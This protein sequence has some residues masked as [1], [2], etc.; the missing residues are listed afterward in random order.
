MQ[1]KS[2]N[3]FVDHFIYALNR[4][5]PLQSFFAYHV[6]FSTTT[7]HLNAYYAKNIP[8]HSIHHYVDYMCQYDPINALQQPQKSVMTQLKHQHIP[9]P[10]SDF[11]KD[12]QV[13]DNIELIFQA[14]HENC[15][16]ISLIRSENEQVFSPQEIEM[17]QSCYDLAQYNGTKHLGSQIANTAC[18]EMIKLLTRSER[19]V[20]TLILTGKKN[21]EIADALFVSLATVKTHIYHIFQKTMVKSK[22]ELILKALAAS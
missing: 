15:L 22:R 1:T 8:Q 3:Q 13:L 6:K 12:N 2:W 14:D 5:V 7:A 19:E 11:L 20:L 21:Q 10:Y 9:Q 4:V 16:A 18:Q 17:I